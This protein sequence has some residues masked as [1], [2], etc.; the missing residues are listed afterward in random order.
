MDCGYALHGEGNPSVFFLR[1]NPAPFAVRAFARVVD[2][3]DPYGGFAGAF[4]ERPRTTDGR[5]C[6]LYPSPRSANSYGG[7]VLTF[8]LK[9]GIVCE[10]GELSERFKE[11]VL[12]TSD[13]ERYREFESHTLRQKKALA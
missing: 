7:A 10:Y 4:L 9:S 13:T 8:L 12:K 5:P 1:K 2:G 11:L 3:A 6:D